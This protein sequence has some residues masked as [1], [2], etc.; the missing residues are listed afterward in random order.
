M[1]GSN[2]VVAT[3]G[4]DTHAFLKE[5]IL[6]S[7]KNGVM[8]L[9]FVSLLAAAHK[10][11]KWLADVLQEDKHYQ[12]YKCAFS[13]SFWLCF[14]ALHIVPMSILLQKQILLNLCRKLGS[15]AA[16]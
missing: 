8:N 5:G 3:F 13:S 1:I 15:I 16:N 11:L 10:L 2:G 9:N 14:P 4:Q 12:N 6:N 7:L